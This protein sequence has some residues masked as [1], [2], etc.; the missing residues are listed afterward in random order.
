M[1]RI[2]QHHIKRNTQT[3]TLTINKTNQNSKAKVASNNKSTTQAA[4]APQTH[5]HIITKHLAS[6]Q[7]YNT[8]HQPIETLI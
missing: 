1:H 4:Q 3:P 6:K 2:K 7:Q 5:Q 8:K